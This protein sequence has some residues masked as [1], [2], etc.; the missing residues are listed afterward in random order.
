MEA[1]RLADEP[2]VPRPQSAIE[3]T[4]GGKLV[5]LNVLKAIAVLI[6]LV[7]LWLVARNSDQ[8]KKNRRGIFYV[9]RLYA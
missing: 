9:D 3:G 2:M 7:L 6:G 1:G 5:E 8:S 4:K